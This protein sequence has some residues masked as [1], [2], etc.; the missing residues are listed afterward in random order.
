MNETLGADGQK[1][2]AQVNV[3]S[4][5]VSLMASVVSDAVTMINRLSGASAESDPNVMP[6]L[7]HE[8]NRLKK[9]V[10]SLSRAPAELCG[11]M[12]RFI[13]SAFDVGSRSA[14]LFDTKHIE[15]V[16]HLQK[17][18][19]CIGTAGFDNKKLAAKAAENLHPKN[20]T[21]NLRQLA[22]MLP[23]TDRETKDKSI[24]LIDSL[25]SLMT[26]SPII[27]TFVDQSAVLISKKA[28]KH[29]PAT[30]L[31]LDSD[32]SNIFID[33]V[34]LEGGEWVTVLDI[35]LE[36]K[37]TALSWVRDLTQQVRYRCSFTL[38]LFHS[39]AT[40]IALA[41]DVISCVLTLML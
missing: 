27:A 32:I 34:H 8:R 40:V 30:R 36:N 15:V 12:L 37:D 29:F 25:V 4:T 5:E 35:K 21:H 17:A 2:V 41:G 20:T 14:I 38:H 18:L 28:A 33:L 13:D 22:A 1:I 24:A 31:A 39:H 9:S 19:S 6:A 3:D 16:D 26:K 11:E 23:G 7:I 10:D